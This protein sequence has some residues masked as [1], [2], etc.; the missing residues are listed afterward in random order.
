MIYRDLTI[1]SNITNYKL[2]PPN[3][4][5]AMNNTC[6]ETAMDVLG[7]WYLGLGLPS[8]D[9]K[10]ELPDHLKSYSDSIGLTRNGI[11][12]FSVVNPYAL[13]NQMLNKGFK[14]HTLTSG[15]LTNGGVIQANKIDPLVT[16]GKIAPTP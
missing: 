2:N 9:S 13:Y 6:A 15:Q 11:T 12:K 3:Y 4:W 7:K 10:V 1:R 14:Q 5:T 8:G 16:H